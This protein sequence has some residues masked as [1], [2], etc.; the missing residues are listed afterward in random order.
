MEKAVDGWGF[1]NIAGFRRSYGKYRPA[2]HYPRTGVFTT[3][4]SN[5][6]TMI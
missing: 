2:R 6:D 4:G 3:D 5:P 1:N